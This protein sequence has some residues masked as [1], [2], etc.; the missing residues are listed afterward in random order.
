M[1]EK[2]SDNVVFIGK[3]PSMAYVLAVVTQIGSGLY[4]WYRHEK[5]R[6]VEEMNGEEN[7]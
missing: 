7:K 2:T 3:K 4:E 5:N 6:T 1:A